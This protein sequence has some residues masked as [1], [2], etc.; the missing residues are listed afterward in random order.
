MDPMGDVDTLAA[1]ANRRIAAAPDLAALLKTLGAMPPE[2]L[3][4]VD[5]PI[6]ARYAG[7]PH[8]GKGCKSNSIAASDMTMLR[9]ATRCLHRR[10]DPTF[11]LIR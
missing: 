9:L 8:T 2:A 10:F 3:Q 4:T 6:L 5:Q 1:E 7:S 11:R